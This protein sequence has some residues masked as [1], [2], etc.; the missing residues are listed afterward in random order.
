MLSIYLGIY[1]NGFY[2]LISFS[3]I[4]LYFQAIVNHEYNYTNCA[5]FPIDFK[6]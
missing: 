4:S 1:Q 2:I 5:Y 6:H 3:N